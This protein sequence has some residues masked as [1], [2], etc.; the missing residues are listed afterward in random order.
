MIFKF[1]ININIMLD[2]DYT[3]GL[4]ELSLKGN[5]ITSLSA[6]VFQGRLTQ[7]SVLELQSNPF[8][9]DCNLISFKT[10][11]DSMVSMCFYFYM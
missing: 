4:R 2:K 1:P 6:E 7:L 8:I 9:C 5:D 10:W 3:A 11:I